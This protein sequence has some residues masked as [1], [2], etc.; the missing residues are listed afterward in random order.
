MQDKRTEVRILCADMMEISWKDGDGRL[1]KMMGLLEDI[2][3]RGACLHME[4]PL[5][6]GTEVTFG[7]PEQ[8]FTGYVRYCVYREV[9]FFAGVEFEGAK[10]SEGTFQ[11]QHS[12]DPRKF[13]APVKETSKGK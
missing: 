9:G 7:T 11:P 8:R 4:C 10:W 5:P 3:P 1:L 6:I 2:S 13:V 12:L